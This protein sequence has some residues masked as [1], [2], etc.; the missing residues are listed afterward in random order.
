MIEGLK[1]EP[2]SISLSGPSKQ[3]ISQNIQMCFGLGNNSEP[4]ENEMKWIRY[5]SQ[6]IGLIDGLLLD[7][8]ENDGEDTYRFVEKTGFSVFVFAFGTV[9]ESITECMR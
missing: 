3:R 6:S 9:T 2:I 7:E 8:H 5:M 4:Q 1:N